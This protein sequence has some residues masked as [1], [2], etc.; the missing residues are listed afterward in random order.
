MSHRIYTT[1]GF[2][3][4]SRPYGEAGKMLSLFT[5]ELGMV[6]ASAAG[7]RLGQSKLRYHTQDFSLSEFSLVRGRD[8]WCLV[9]AE[10][11]VLNYHHDPFFIRIL[12]VLRRLIH[13]EE[14]NEALFEA[15]MA[16][17]DFFNTR[18][19]EKTEDVAL[20]TLAEPVIMLRILHH[21]G[22]IRKKPEL[23]IF[24]TDNSF[25]VELLKKMSVPTIKPLAIREINKALE[26]SHL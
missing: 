16:A 8:L 23:E 9:G 22:Y 4:E 1:S 5:R 2:V 15:V 24:L 21:L 6:N 12:A 3:I 14:K 26:E 25:A 18:R 17:Y 11:I 19:I 7:I 13:G 10:R 20:V